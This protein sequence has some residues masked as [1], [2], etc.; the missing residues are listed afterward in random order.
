MRLSETHLGKQRS[1]NKNFPQGFFI[2]LVQNDLCETFTQINK[3]QVNSVY[4][5]IIVP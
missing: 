5:K 3:G 1:F 2:D 4:K